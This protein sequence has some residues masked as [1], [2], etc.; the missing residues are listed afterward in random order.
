M[1]SE[2]SE[3]DI[4]EK[5]FLECLKENQKIT[6]SVYKK[7]KNQITEQVFDPNN[8]EMI[9]SQILEYFNQ[10]DVTKINKEIFLLIPT[11]LI[12]FIH[13]FYNVKINSTYTE[14][15]LKRIYKKVWSYSE[16]NLRSDIRLPKS[17]VYT[18]FDLPIDADAKN[19]ASD[20][21]DTVNARNGF[22]LIKDVGITYENLDDFIG[23]FLFTF[24]ELIFDLE[25]AK[26]AAIELIKLI[27]THGFGLNKHN[28][29]RIHINDSLYVEMLTTLIR[30]H[31]DSNNHLIEECIGALKNKAR[32]SCNMHGLVVSHIATIM[33]ENLKQV[34]LMTFALQSKSGSKKLSDTV[35]D[36]RKSLRLQ[37]DQISNMQISGNENT[38]PTGEIPLDTSKN[39][40]NKSKKDKKSVLS[41]TT[42]DLAAS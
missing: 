37:S 42:K 34:D 25:L 28:E 35:K 14:N 15:F 9:L 20:I 12:K 40:K 10:V 13:E 7:A 17:D 27:N 8:D 21:I 11:I 33:I 6:Q 30:C 2:T 4:G 23:T 3:M 32:A 26:P 5:S 22:D 18:I 16:N 29:I 38:S 31:R 36:V 39:L 41:Q 24:N 1:V 19:L